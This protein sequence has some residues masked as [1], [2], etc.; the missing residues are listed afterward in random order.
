MI[1]RVVRDIK[2]NP[3]TKRELH[4]IDSY[5]SNSNLANAPNLLDP[6]ISLPITELDQICELGDATP[7]KL[8]DLLLRVGLSIV[9]VLLVSH[10]NCDELNGGDK[11]EE[12]DLKFGSKQLS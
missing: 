11:H 3:G 7:L 12:A 9:E 5:Q 6:L 8:L 4:K 2:V 10:C 1:P